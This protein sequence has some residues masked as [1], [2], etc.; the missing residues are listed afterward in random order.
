MR[1]K[2]MASR[3][4]VAYHLICEGTPSGR[5]V[6]KWIC[7]LRVVSISSEAPC[8]ISRA[9]LRRLPTAIVANILQPGDRKAK[10]NTFIVH[11]RDEAAKFALKNYLQ[12]SLGLSEPIILHEQPS[13]LVAQS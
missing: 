11:G 5:G 12:N 3:S 7:R 2:P 1:L 4:V 6:G 10:L 9:I 13:P 8:G